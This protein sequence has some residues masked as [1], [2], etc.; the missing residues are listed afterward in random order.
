[1]YLHVVINAERIWQQKGEI[2]A[3]LQELILRLL[4]LQLKRQRCCTLVWA[5]LVTLSVNYGQ[6]GFL[7]ST[8]WMIEI[9]D[10]GCQ[11]VPF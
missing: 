7:K 3:Y 4:N 5:H 9:Q 11:M 8:S 10:Q 2:I 1:M 6:N